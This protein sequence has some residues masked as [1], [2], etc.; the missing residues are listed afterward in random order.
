MDAF[1]GNET[2]VLEFDPRSA[3]FGTMVGM[4]ESAYF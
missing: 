4:F 3:A 2:L 1:K